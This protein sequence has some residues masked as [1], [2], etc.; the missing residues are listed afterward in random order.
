MIHAGSEK[1]PF[2]PIKAPCLAF[3]V[4]TNI[5]YWDE[6]EI[7][8]RVNKINF[9]SRLQL[10]QNYTAVKMSPLKRHLSTHSYSCQVCS[11]LVYHTEGDEKHISSRDET[12]RP[13]D[14]ISM[15][16]SLDETHM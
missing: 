3:P 7:K 11:N 1:E 13:P 9:S 6:M 5:V 8:T 12:T 16:L 4:K 14:E 10:Q 15:I 2:K